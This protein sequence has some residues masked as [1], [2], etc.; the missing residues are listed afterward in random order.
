[1]INPARKIKRPIM[2]IQGISCILQTS[3]EMKI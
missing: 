1:M 3:P 2:S